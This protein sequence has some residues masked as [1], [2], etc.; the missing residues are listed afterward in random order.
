[1]SNVLIGIIG[2]ILFIGLALAGALFLGPRFQQSTNS[3]R[4]SAI[5]QAVNQVAQ[6][7]Q[8]R[9]L[10][11]GVR[12]PATI[13]LQTGL[14]DAGYLKA[15]PANPTDGGGLYIIDSGGGNS[16][17]AN[18]A[19]MPLK[20]DGR[21]KEICLLIAKQTGHSTDG[22]I[23]DGANA[24]PLHPVGCTYNGGTNYTAFARI[25]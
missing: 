18:Y 3:S 9:D 10:Q 7:V 15:I 2:V 4:A 8:M 25:R 16:G 22:T 19:I 12:T 13:N 6:S 14:V 5:V 17:T 24:I 1:M 23:P 11:E 21:E 20:V